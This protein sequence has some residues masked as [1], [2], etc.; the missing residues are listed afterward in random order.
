MAGSSPH[1]S[2]ISSRE[3]S[4]LADGTL[5]PAR[6]EAVEAQINAS[7]EL[8]ELYE[9]ERR[10]V[11][12]LHEARASDRA[13]DQLRAR[14]ERMRPSERTRV[15]R[16]LQLG[17]GFAA[18]LAAGATALILALPAG[19]P[20]APSVSQAASLAVRGPA[21]PL[22]SDGSA[23][24]SS[25]GADIEEV[26]FPNWQHKFHWRAVGERVDRINGRKAVTVYYDGHGSRIAYTIIAAPVL[27]QPAASMRWLHGTELRTLNLGSRLVVTWRRAGHTCVLSGTGVSADV[28]QKLAAW[29]VP[30]TNL[31]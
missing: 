24:P 2:N 11:E 29:K 16:R 7:P 21:G 5:D 13:P 17:G 19:A 4:S 14:I 25:V 30:T 10:V 12:L 3:I 15:R 8:S 1:T 22:Y 26:Y 9:R 31:S 20:G 27:K 6:R 23:P 28:L 18:A